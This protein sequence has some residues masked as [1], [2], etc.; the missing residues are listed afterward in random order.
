MKYKGTYINLNGE[1]A[2]FHF[3]DRLTVSQ[4]LGFI[5]EMANRTVLEDIGLVRLIAGTIIDYCTVKYFTDIALF[6]N[7]DDFDLDKVEQFSKD[8]D[9]NV[10]QVIMAAVDDRE[11]DALMYGWEEAAEFR[12]QKILYHTKVNSKTLQST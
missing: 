3:T 5:R 10:M 2:E 11:Y 1:S 7:E 12:K 4:E 9:E 8:N 6:E